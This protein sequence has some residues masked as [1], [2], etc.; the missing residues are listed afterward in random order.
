[1]GII[2]YIW[3]GTSLLLTSLVLCSKYHQTARPISR[4]IYTLRPRLPCIHSPSAHSISSPC[5]LRLEQFTQEESKN[6]MLLINSLVYLRSPLV[7]L[8]IDC[9]V[10]IYHV[11]ES[12]RPCLLRPRA[13]LRTRLGALNKERHTQAGVLTFACM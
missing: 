3:P 12:S 13:P 9:V 8:Y 5:Q 2:F 6:D 1:M 4:P 11:G 10:Y 7:Y